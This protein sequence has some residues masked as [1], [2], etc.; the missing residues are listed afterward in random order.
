M[1]KWDLFMRRSDFLFIYKMLLL[2][3][4]RIGGGPRAFKGAFSINYKNTRINPLPRM[5]ALPKKKDSRVARIKTDPA[6]KKKKQE[7]DKEEEKKSPAKTPFKCD[8]V[9]RKHESLLYGVNAGVNRAAKK[10]AAFDMDSTLIFTKSGAIFA[11]NARDWKFFDDTVKP[12]LERL[13]F[14]EGMRLVVFTNQ[15]GIGSGKVNEA[16]YKEKILLIQK[17]LEVPLTLLAATDND[18][19]RKPATGM[20]HFFTAKLCEAEVDKEGSFYC[21]DAAGRKKTKTQKA[22]FS[23]GDIKFAKNLG[24]SFNLPEEM[25]GGG[26]TSDKGIKKFLTSKE[27]EKKTAA[28]KIDGFNPKDLPT[29]GTIFI[30]GKDEELTKEE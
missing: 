5:D 12:T 17:A 18:K 29:S 24:I 10:I 30:D 21:G 4:M 8:M 3:R 6:E 9:W 25:F 2:L 26:S 7:E 23:D 11:K 1:R 28:P 14:E 27:E 19:Y 15:A 16:E 20:W 13:V 22:D